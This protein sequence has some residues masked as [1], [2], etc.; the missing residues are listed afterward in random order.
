MAHYLRFFNHGRLVA[1]LRIQNPAWWTFGKIGIRFSLPGQRT[2]RLRT[3]SRH[4][5][6][7]ANGVKV[8]VGRHPG[9][10][11][12]VWIT[13]NDD[14]VKSSFISLNPR[15]MTHQEIRVGPPIPCRVVNR[16]GRFN[17]CA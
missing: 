6:D 12:S 14:R 3:D 15:H 1:K 7:L 17:V 8:V 16:S 13:K 5:L 10:I 11:V 9:N 2:L 4:E